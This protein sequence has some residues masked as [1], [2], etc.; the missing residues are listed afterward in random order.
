[1]Y[2]ATTLNM[3]CLGRDRENMAKCRGGK[4]AEHNTYCKID[5]AD[6]S[7][8]NSWGFACGFADKKVGGQCGPGGIT[9]AT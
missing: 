7:D 6:T 9:V 4:P 3:N 8:S 5:L 2:F 1:M